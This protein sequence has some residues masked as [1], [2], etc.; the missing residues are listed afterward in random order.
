MSK[1]MNLRYILCFIYPFVL[2]LVGSLFK[3][4]PHLQIGYN[5][6]STPSSRKSQETWDYA[7]K[8]A[9]DIFIKC[10]KI[11]FAISTVIVIYSLIYKTITI[12]NCITISSIIGIVGVIVSFL[13]VETKLNKI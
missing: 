11:L 10:G 12:D 2:V 13:I 4:H 8:I 3:K 6:Y 5:G 1:L 7:Q 9:P